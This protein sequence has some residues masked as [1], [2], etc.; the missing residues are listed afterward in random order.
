[1]QQWTPPLWRASFAK[2]LISST[3]HQPSG[4]ADLPWRREIFSKT[5]RTSLADRRHEYASRPVAAP[6]RVL[7]NRLSYAEATA[8]GQTGRGLPLFAVNFYPHLFS[9]PMALKQRIGWLV[10]PFIPFDTAPRDHTQLAESFRNPAATP[11]SR[12]RHLLSEGIARCRARPGRPEPGDKPRCSRRF[13]F[14]PIRMRLEHVGSTVPTRGQILGPP[15][16]SIHRR[17]SATPSFSATQRYL[18]CGIGRCWSDRGS[19]R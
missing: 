10:I 19:T 6:A 18:F 1:M 11:L 5:R 14:P 12:Y 2:P 4:K 3:S 8:S 13:P 15:P 9:T 7:L 16:L 17:A